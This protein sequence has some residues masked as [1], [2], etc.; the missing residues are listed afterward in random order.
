MANFLHGIEV[1]EI[2]DQARTMVTGSTSVIG[3]IGTAP[4]ADVNKVEDN[5]PTLVTNINQLADFGT[6][7]TLP[8]ALQEIYKQ[9]SPVI[10]A[11]KVEEGADFD[12]TLA[13]IEGSQLQ[14]TGVWAFLK[15]EN[16]VKVKPKILIAPLYSSATQTDQTQASLDEALINV[17]DQLRA[18][19]I[20][21]SPD[22]TRDE[23][24]A[25]ATNINS[26]RMLLVD[27]SYN[28]TGD[29]SLVYPASPIVAGVI[30]KN[31]NDVNFGWWTNPS[32]KAI[33]GIS[34]LNRAIS[35][36]ISDK[37]SDANKLNEAG[38]I[39]FRYSQGNW[40]TWGQ[41]NLSK[42]G[43][44]AFIQVR[45]VADAIYD[46]I[47]ASYEWA[48]ALNF[49]AGVLD[50]INTSLQDYLNSLKA[51]GAILGGTIKIDPQANPISELKQGKLVVEF[52]FEPSASIE[53]LTF[54][55]YR[56][57]GYYEEIFG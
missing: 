33:V 56:N 26:S 20:K 18:I 29:K 7:G 34:S 53:R 51:K 36:S 31:D 35:A 54:K 22:T 42:D 3:L 39:T 45:R 37:T 28:P 49:N 46:A 30:A 1:L 15:A 50:T 12:Q 11:I 21:E 48:L 43:Q 9:T 16:E 52:D 57:D 24:I 19:V 6:T 40:K 13:F 2:Q 10:V 27:P 17:A 32:N 5:K 38:V 47:E 23:A 14:Q 55:A 25:V 44:W 8:Q 41:R 4:E